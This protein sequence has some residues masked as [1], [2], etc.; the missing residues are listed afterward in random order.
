MKNAREQK[1][2]LLKS[3]RKPTT[4][5][6]ITA[7]SAKIASPAFPRATTL[8]KIPLSRYHRPPYRWTKN[9]RSRNSISLSGAVAFKSHYPDPLSRSFLGGN[10]SLGWP[11][12]N[13]CPQEVQEVHGD[14]IVR[15][16][17]TVLQSNWEPR[18]TKLINTLINKYGF[19]IRRLCFFESLYY[20]GD[21][22]L[23]QAT[24]IVV[25]R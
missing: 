22:F 23:V 4:G 15:R 7:T 20:F 25:V 12:S 8:K 16:N 1:A 11:S 24:T 5:A 18:E 14:P 6:F 13:F 10:S 17:S 19:T 3:L 21:A 2:R 9:S